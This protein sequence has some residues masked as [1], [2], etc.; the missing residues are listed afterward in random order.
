MEN[1]RRSLALQAALIILPVVLLSGFSLYFL[2]EDRGAIERDARDQA[3][4]LGPQLARGFAIRLAEAIRTQPAGEIGRSG[5]VLSPADYPRLPVP[6][7][8]PGQLSRA[9]EALWAAAQT[10]TFQRKDP[11]A[12]RPAYT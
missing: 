6:A 12:A 11:Q 5:E 7:E 1:S 2:R 10:A 3:Q 4:R 9:D 8:W